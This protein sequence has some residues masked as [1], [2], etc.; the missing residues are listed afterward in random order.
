MKQVKSEEVAKDGKQDQTKS[1]F[2]I[3]DDEANKSIWPFFFSNEAIPE[4]ARIPMKCKDLFRL[5]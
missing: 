3:K 2:E 5:K 4:A 1:T